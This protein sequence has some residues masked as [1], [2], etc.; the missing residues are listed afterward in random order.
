MEP[1]WLLFSVCLNQESIPSYLGMGPFQVAPMY[2][3]NR[4]DLHLAM[5]EYAKELGVQCHL[6]VNVGE[7]FEDNGKAGIIVEGKRIEGDLLIAAVC[8]Y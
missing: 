8:Y 5:F 4:A 7:Y 2:D 3:I 6:G 1:F